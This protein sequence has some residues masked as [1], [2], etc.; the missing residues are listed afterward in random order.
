MKRAIDSLAPRRLALQ[1]AALQSAHYATSSVLIFFTCLVAGRQFALDYVLSWRSVRV[2]NTFGLTICLLWILT[3][4]FD[5]LVLTLV[6]GRS[7]LV[8]DFVL[9]NQ[10]LGLIATWIY[11]GAFPISGPWWLL[12]VCAVLFM[13]SLGTWTSRW[14]ELSIMYF[15]AP[16][17]PRSPDIELAER[18]EADASPK[19][20]A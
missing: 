11:T 13:C 18:G 12:Q 10:L 20:A 9:T 19:P 6:V 5:V 15:A 4:G 1:I 7:K 8:L 17:Q 16:T 3:A 14:R 2:D